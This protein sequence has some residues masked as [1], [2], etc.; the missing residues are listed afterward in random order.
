MV[1]WNLL[2]AALA[3]RLMTVTRATG[4]LTRL[5]VF[6]LADVLIAVVITWEYER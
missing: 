3:F 4:L 6:N 5:A 1:P 2:E